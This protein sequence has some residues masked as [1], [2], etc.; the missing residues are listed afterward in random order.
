MSRYRIPTSTPGVT[1]VVGWD[2]PMSTFFAQ[3]AREQDDNDERD[4]V[5]LWLGGRIGEI[6]R[7]VDVAPRLAPYAR[8]DPDM[9]AQL[10]ADRASCAGT[11][12][13]PLQRRM[14]ERFG[15]RR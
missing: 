5:I 1:V 13:T 3:V 7:A 4:P 6:G 2:N 15:R 8:L 12:P 9:L 10:E 14:L 11:G